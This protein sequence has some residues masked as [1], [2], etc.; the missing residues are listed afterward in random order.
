MKSK[1]YKEF[2][3]IVDIEKEEIVQDNDQNGVFHSKNP[4]M[5]LI[6][7]ARSKDMDPIEYYHIGADQ[8]LSLNKLQIIYKELKN[9]ILENNLRSLDV[10]EDGEQYLIVYGK[11]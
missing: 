3:E 7:V 9:Y 5:Q 8:K 10:F 1:H 4:Y 2:G 11:V 6:N